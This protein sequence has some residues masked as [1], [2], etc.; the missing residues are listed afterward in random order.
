MGVAFLFRTSARAPPMMID[1]LCNVSQSAAAAAAA[2]RDIIII[3]IIVSV[4]VVHAFV[5]P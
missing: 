5:L 4:S 1:G 2:A 3:I